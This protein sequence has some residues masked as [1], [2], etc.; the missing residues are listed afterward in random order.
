MYAQNCLF[1]ALECS[2]RTHSDLDKLMEALFFICCLPGLE[3]SWRGMAP[4]P[5]TIL[6]D[7]LDS[8]TVGLHTLWAPAQFIATKQG[9]EAQTGPAKYLYITGKVH[10]SVCAQ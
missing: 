2:N 1:R 8:L 6:H 5:G 4:S 7:C 3:A 10:V 9:E